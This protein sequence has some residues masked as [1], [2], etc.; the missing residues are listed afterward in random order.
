M[1]VVNAQSKTSTCISHAV[2]NIFS[3]TPTIC[4]F[5]ISKYISSSYFPVIRLFSY[6]TLLLLIITNSR[7]FA[8]KM[9]RIQAHK[10]AATIFILITAFRLL[11]SISS[12]LFF[13]YIQFLRNSTFLT[14]QSIFILK[15]FFL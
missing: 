8:S 1:F 14:T 10:K 9:R 3:N 12:F 6:F 7:R 13:F 5:I 2:S 4:T 15:F 11:F